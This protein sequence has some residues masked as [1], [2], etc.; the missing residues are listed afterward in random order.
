[1]QRIWLW[2]TIVPVLCG[3]LMVGACMSHAEQR[4]SF[5]ILW[6]YDTSGYLETCGCSSHQLGGLPRRATL[7][8]DL[9]ARQ[10]VLAIEGAHIVE[11]KGDFQL[12]KGEMIVRLLSQ[13]GYNAML[14]GVLSEPCTE[15]IE[16]SLA[17]SSE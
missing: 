13:M 11:D 10:P 1:M 4:Q 12:F 2:I 15:A 6:N 16:S 17:F 7:L 14:L 9:R 3:A 8:A 5:A